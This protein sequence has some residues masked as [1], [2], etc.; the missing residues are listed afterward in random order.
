MIMS[1]PLARIRVEEGHNHRTVFDPAELKR[2][3]ANIAEYGLTSPIT[4]RPD[5]E[6]ADHYRVVAG[7]R[8]YRAHQLLGRET[9][10]CYVRTLDDTAAYQAMLAENLS[11]VDPD[12]LDEAAGYQRGLDTGYEVEQIAGMAGVRVGRVQAR[13]GLLNLIDDIAQM[14]KGG[15]ITPGHGE[16]VAR[17]DRNRQV[18]ALKLLN[19]DDRLLNWWAFSRL[20]DRLYNEQQKEGFFDPDEFLMQAEEYV[21]EAVKKA[22]VLPREMAPLLARFADEL[23]RLT[24]GEL[25]E[26]QT[27]MVTTARLAA[28]QY[29]GKVR[30]PKAKED[31]GG[32]TQAA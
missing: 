21:I 17:L 9:V 14:V 32:A 19:E 1:I 22:H 26:E 8:R 6:L 12:P 11:R 4:V 10:D 31:A 2:L 30:K 3:A 20:C 7:E 23:E 16:T 15:Q 25:D 24:G 18:V 27:R 5:E 29:T 13:L 28:S